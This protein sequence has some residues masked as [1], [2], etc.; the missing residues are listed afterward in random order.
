L[1]KQSKDRKELRE[2]DNRKISYKRRARAKKKHGWKEKKKYIH[3]KG[4][5]LQNKCANAQKSKQ[6]PH[7]QLQVQRFGLLN[8]SVWFT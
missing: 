5:T 3:K 7:K 1:R 2:E 4:S 6:Q 8:Q